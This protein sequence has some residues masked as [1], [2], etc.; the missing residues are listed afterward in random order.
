MVKGWGD[1]E[2]LSM[3]FQIHWNSKNWYLN[4]Y[5]LGKTILDSLIENPQ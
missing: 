4:W 5:S 1:S 3:Q 2:T